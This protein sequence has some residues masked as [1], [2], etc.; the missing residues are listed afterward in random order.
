MSEIEALDDTTFQ[1]SQI[2]WEAIPILVDQALAGLDLEEEEVSA[3]SY[4]R[5][6]GERPRV[7][8]GVSGLRGNGRLIANADGT[9]VEVTR[10]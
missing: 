4:D 1:P 7:Y 2:A 9:E 5:I 10:N 3:V 8:I 6:A